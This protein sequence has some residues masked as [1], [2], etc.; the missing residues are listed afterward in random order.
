MRI[1][2]L[3]AENIKKL[4]AVEI[5][6]EGNVVIISGRN[7]QG[8]T[9]VLDCIWLALAGADASKGMPKPIRT[10]EKKAN[11][12]LD[13]GD[14]V[15]T[16]TWTDNDKSYLLD[17]RERSIIVAGTLGIEVSGY[18]NE[19]A[20]PAQQ[21]Y[22]WEA[23]YIEREDRVYRII[24]V[25]DPAENYVDAFHGMLSTFAPASLDQ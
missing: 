25:Q 16:R 10:G 14:L 9:S 3:K 5:T 4:K 6:P 2:T 21:G 19:K 15:V 12:T 17:A 1:I 11:T 23:I 13:L 20:N 24:L 22:Y 18:L 7:E 8:K